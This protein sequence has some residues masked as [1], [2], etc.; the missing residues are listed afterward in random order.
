MLPLLLEALGGLTRP[1]PVTVQV[2][3]SA[4][5]EAIEAQANACGVELR[6][7]GPSPSPPMT[8]FATAQLVVSHGGYGTVLE[9]L[10]CGTP[11]L[12]FSS[13]TADRMEVA[14]RVI[15]SGFGA[16]LNPYRATALQT[17]ATIERLLADKELQ[18]RA[19]VAAAA[20]ERAAAVC[21]AEG[22]AAR[23]LGSS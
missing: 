2:Q 22:R 17:R 11:V 23:V 13:V 8:L 1:V 14:R 5:R 7:V 12:L 10:A 3:D 4:R 6:V 15:E 9:S 19:C 18:Q 21:K 16:V 20:I